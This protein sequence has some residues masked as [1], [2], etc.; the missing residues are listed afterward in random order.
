MLQN[1]AIY[2][3]MCVCERERE[4]ERLFNYLICRALFNLDGFK[5][6]SWNLGSDMRTYVYVR[7]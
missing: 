7:T 1:S 6:W 2:I 3:Y 4:R 5:G